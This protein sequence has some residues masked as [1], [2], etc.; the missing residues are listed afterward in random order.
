MSN[1]AK[2]VRPAKNLESLT[3]IADRAGRSFKSST[4]NSRAT[5]LILRSVRDGSKVQR[6]THRRAANGMLKVCLRDL[7]GSGFGARS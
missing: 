4:A 3:T 1:Y 5:N 2:R 7:P 6:V